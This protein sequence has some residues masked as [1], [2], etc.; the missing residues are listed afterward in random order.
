[1]SEPTALSGRDN[2]VEILTNMCSELAAGADW[3]N[4]TLPRYLEALA[5]L[6]ESIENSYTN[7]GL[8]VPDDPWEII[9]KALRG[10]REYE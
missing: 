7:S 3:E 10:A 4:D 8:P 1:M 9:G 5:A 2:V 6:L